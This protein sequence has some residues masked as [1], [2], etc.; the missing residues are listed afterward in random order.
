VIFEILNLHVLKKNHVCDVYE[1]IYLQT[2]NAK[3]GKLVIELTHQGQTSLIQEP[4][5]ISGI[6]NLNFLKHFKKPWISLTFSKWPLMGYL[7]QI[8]VNAYKKDLPLKVTDNI[9]SQWCSDWIMAKK[10]IISFIS[11]NTR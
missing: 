3:L 10:L 4:T 1:D 7:L 6:L 8:A 9:W 11:L 5:L 2:C